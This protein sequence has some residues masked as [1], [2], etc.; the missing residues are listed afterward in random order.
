VPKVE[1]KPTDRLDFG[2][3]FLRNPDTLGIQLINNSDL[4]A[5]F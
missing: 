1:I 3:I 4:K 2:E 5:K